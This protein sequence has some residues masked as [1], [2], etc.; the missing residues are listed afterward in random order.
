MDV[1][2]PVKCDSTIQ[3]GG[4]GE[5]AMVVMMEMDLRHI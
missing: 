1:V 4:D 3:V 5:L 2:R